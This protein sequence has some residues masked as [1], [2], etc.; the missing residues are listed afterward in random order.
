MYIIMY[1]YICIYIYMYIIKIHIYIY[2]YNVCT[3]NMITYDTT[4][5]HYG[6][7]LGNKKHG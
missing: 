5:T 6:S 7:D 3:E 1:I 4:I 2:I